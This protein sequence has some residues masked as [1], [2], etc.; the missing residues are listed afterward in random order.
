MGRELQINKIEEIIS[1]LSFRN[2]DFLNTY[3]DFLVWC[4]EKGISFK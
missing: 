3:V 4:E 2:Y 1:K